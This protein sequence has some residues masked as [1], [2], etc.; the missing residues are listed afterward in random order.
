MKK[1]NFFIIG[2]PKCGTTS[3][4]AWLAEHPTIYMSPVK[5]PHF[6]CSDFNV[7]II[8]NEA[9]YYR[10]FKKAG[11]QHMAVGE[12]STSYLYSQ[13]AV[14]RIERELP[15]A[16]YIVM[17]RNPVEM[18]YS[19]H[20]HYIFWG[21]EHI[22]DFETAWRLSPE[23]RAGRMVSRW[24]SEPRLLDYQ[25]TCKLGEQLE[26]LF[27]IVPRERVL[28]LVLDDIKENPRQE[29][30]KVL[31]FLGVSD[32]GRQAF[33]VKNPAKERR[34]PKLY[35]VLRLIGRASRKTKQLL[36]IPTNRGTGILKAINN[37][38]VKY[39]PRPSMPI[40]LRKELT[41]YFRPD[42]EKLGGLLGRDF[43]H[44]LSLPD[45]VENDS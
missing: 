31:G 24:C 11:D 35:K 12:A 22:R 20:D 17:V 21:I 36:G 1:P 18:A 28:V 37:I 15:G 13:V 38:N 33:P 41:E 5:E 42:I 6:F 10:L 40:Q 19:L 27:S 43:S 4:A 8:P 25:S 14:P 3:L 26:R 9:E 39:R 23:R 45:E 2:A 32:D 7:V 29:Y 16:K 34:R 44:W 30:L